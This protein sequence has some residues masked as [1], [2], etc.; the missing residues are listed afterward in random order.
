MRTS[1]PANEK[2]KKVCDYF[3]NLVILTKS[4]TIGG[5]QLTLAHTSVGNKSLGESVTAFAL[6]GSLNSTSIVS[7]DANI[8]FAMD[9][10]RIRLPIYE[11]L[12][13]AA[14]GNLARSKNQRDW[15]PLNTIFLLPILME[16]EIFDMETSMEDLLK[17]FAC[18]IT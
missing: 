12:L 13:C 17:I 10:D 7:I 9:G 14:T 1:E 11:V 4:A 8:A 5:I 3:P 6:V 18:T 2:Y 16:A 15:T